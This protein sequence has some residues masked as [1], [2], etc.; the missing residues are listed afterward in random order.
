YLLT[1]AQRGGEAEAVLRKGVSVYAAA[2]A[3][4]LNHR[5]R[6]GEARTRLAL[7]L[8]LAEAGRGQ[9]FLTEAEDALTLLED[10][11]RLPEPPARAPRQYR[12]AT[13][14]I[15]K[16]LIDVPATADAER[17]LRRVLAF[18]QEMQDRDGRQTGALIE[19]LELLARVQEQR[20]DKD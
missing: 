17:V 20:G 18:L 15:V 1:Q 6:L 7:G 10:L 8:V 13:A 2:A 4:P 12:E 16:R 3:D 9:P 11:Q 5:A 19:M 14:S